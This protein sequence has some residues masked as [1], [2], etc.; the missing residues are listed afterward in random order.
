MN[1][2]DDRF[3]KDNDAFDL[4]LGDYDYNEIKHSFTQLSSAPSN[5]RRGAERHDSV[6][7]LPHSNER[8]WLDTLYQ[9]YESSV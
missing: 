9:R 3:K 5:L 7:G 8:R 6:Y 4:P 2:M 1:Q